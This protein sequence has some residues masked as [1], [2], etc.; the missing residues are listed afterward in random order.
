[1]NTQ[2][3]FR[4]LKKLDDLKLIKLM[5]GNKVQFPDGKV[6]SVSTF[7][8]PLEKLKH[9]LTLKFVKKVSRSNNGSIFGGVFFLSQDESTSL[10]EDL[11]E[12][13]NKYTKR[14]LAN[15]SLKKLKDKSN[16]STITNMIVMSPTSLF[17]DIENL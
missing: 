6:G 5:P 8:T 10:M 1:L 16:Y 11:K 2:S 17:E 7:G 3:I 12:I 15:R 9:I 14:S 4:Y 13:Q